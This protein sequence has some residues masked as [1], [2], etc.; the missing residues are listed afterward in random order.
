MSL[1]VLAYQIQFIISML[2]VQL[3]AISLL[4]LTWALPRIV[5]SFGSNPLFSS[6]QVWNKQGT[7]LGK[8]FINMTSANMAFAGDGR[9]VILAETKIFLAKIAAKPIRTLVYPH[10]DPAA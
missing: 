3:Q 9:L 1:H 5:E 8:F 2:L 4:F 10:P 6:F 7:L